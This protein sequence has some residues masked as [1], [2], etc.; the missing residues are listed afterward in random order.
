MSASAKVAYV[1]VLGGRF[2]YKFGRLGQVQTAW[3][4]AGAKMYQGNGDER[5]DIERLWGKGKDPVF[6]QVCLMA[7]PVVLTRGTGK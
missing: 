4:L 6:T 3:C 5:K 7:A 2:F 1:I